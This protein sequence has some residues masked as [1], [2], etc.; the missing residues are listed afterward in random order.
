MHLEIILTVLADLLG[1]S[2]RWFI[3]TMAREVASPDVATLWRMAPILILP[4][5][6]GRAFTRC[7]FVLAL[8]LVFVELYFLFNRLTIFSL[9]PLSLA[10]LLGNVGLITLA[11]LLL[12]PKRSIPRALEVQPHD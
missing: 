9:K 6:A 2:V 10:E 5:A 1:L 4:F 8:A 7:R 11:F 3:T 12:L